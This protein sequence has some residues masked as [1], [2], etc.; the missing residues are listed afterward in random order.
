MSK[1]TPSQRG[2]HSRNKG[3]TFER[4]VVLEARE[5]GLT[6]MR[7]P[8]SGATEFQKGD[9]IITPTF[10]DKPWVFECKRRKTLPAWLEEALGDNAGLILRAD[11]HEAV[12]VIPF[13]T[14]L[15]LMQ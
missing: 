1:R 8:L 13:A 15:E 2:R 10:S 6:A 12:A 14:L 5:H 11:R 9:V 7:V 4:S 3:A